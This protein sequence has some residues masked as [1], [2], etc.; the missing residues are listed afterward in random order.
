[1]KCLCG[2]SRSSIISKFKDDYEIGTSCGS[3]SGLYEQDR[4]TQSVVKIKVVK[5]LVNGT[6]QFCF[7]QISQLHEWYLTYQRANDLS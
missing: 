5:P 3:L 1:M 7:L 2:Q 4:A 6:S